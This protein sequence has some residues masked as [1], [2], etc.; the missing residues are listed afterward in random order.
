VP[1]TKKFNRPDVFGPDCCFA[2][3]DWRNFL[4]AAA[5]EQATI[6][7]TINEVETPY[8]VG[9]RSALANSYIRFNWT[10]YAPL[11]AAPRSIFIQA[12][13]PNK[14]A[15]YIHACYGT[16][17]TRNSLYIGTDNTPMFY[18]GYAGEDDGGG[19]PPATWYTMGV[20]N[21]GV[22]G[23]AN[24]V[25]GQGNQVAAGT[26]SAAAV[27]TYGDLYLFTYFAL[28]NQCP[29]GTIIQSVILFRRM[30]SAAEH[31]DLHDRCIGNK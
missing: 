6:S 30:L 20:S 23:G 25:Y 17:A 4:G 31:R 26:N 12:Y 16:P 22:N 18:G 3:T 27:T 14:D 13:T 15:P 21:A 9:V 11:G 29:V 2:V 24:I 8:G 5:Q 19:T 10:G 1:P 7:G 28:G